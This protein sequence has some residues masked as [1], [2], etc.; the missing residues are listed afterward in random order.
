M[1]DR[2]GLKCAQAIMGH[3]GMYVSGTQSWQTL[4]RAK[5]GQ[6][7]E[8]ATPPC[9]TAVKEQE[10]WIYVC[11]EMSRD[12]HKRLRTSFPLRT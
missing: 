4:G 5:P 9:L 8:Q 1:R 12:V 7:R 6:G 10:G 2:K 11:K 3:L